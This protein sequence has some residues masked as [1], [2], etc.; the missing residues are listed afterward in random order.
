MPKTIYSIDNNSQRPPPY[1][2]AYLQNNSQPFDSK[3][4][5]NNTQF[6]NNFYRTQQEI[7]Y[8]PIESIPLNRIVNNQLNATQALNDAKL[9][10]FFAKYEISPYIQE[11][12]YH[13]RDY[14]I[15]LLCDDSSSM[16]E[17]SEYLSFYTN[18]IVRKTRWEELKETIDVLVE[19]G[20]LMDESGVDVWFLNKNTPNKNIKTK[21]QVM[22]LFKH[23]PHGRTPLTRALYKIMSEYTNKPKLILIATDGE[24]TDDQGNSDFV[25]FRRLLQTRNADRNR[26]GILACTGD[27]SNWRG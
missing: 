17:Q 12:I 5:D 1:N 16:K 10:D 13:L 18:S 24:P 19:L 8:E 26:I 2:V 11:D 15:I 3:Q 7:L 23:T 9:N 27:E 4:Y 22:D 14:E 20:V 6:N 21:E 25:N